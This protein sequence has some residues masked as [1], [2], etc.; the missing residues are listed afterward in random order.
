MAND[1]AT[2]EGQISHNVEN[3]VPHAFVWKPQRVV[4]RSMRAKDQQMLRSQFVCHLPKYIPD[5]L[6]LDA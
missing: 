5:N 3:L 4:D 2:G 6:R 1:L